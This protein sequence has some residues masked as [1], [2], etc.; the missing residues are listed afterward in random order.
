[1][2][3][4]GN[5]PE[6]LVAFHRLA[7]LRPALHRFHDPVLEQPKHASGPFGD[8]LGFAVQDEAGMDW[9]IPWP[10]EG[11]GAADPRVWYTDDPC[12][13][14]PET[15]IEDD[16]LS[17]FLLQFTLYEATIAAPYQAWTYCLPTARL[18][19]LWSMLRPIPNRVWGPWWFPD[20]VGWWR[21]A[22]GTSP[23]G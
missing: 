15:F 7:R 16:P 19:T 3:E 21:P 9:S 12:A 14:E 10:L 17:R 8:R 20:E 22:T 1:M 23:T 18:D 4:L 11:P 6:A 13:T 2:G 5:L